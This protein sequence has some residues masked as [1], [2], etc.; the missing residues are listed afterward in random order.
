M[1]SL[2]YSLHTLLPGM[3]LNTCYNSSTNLNLFQSFYLMSFSCILCYFCTSI[4]QLA[5]FLSNYSW[6]DSFIYFLFY[7]HSFMMKVLFYHSFMMNVLF[8]IF[9]ICSES[10]LI[11]SVYL[12]CLV[13]LLF[14]QIFYTELFYMTYLKILMSKF[15]FFFLRSTFIFVCVTLIHGSWFSCVYGIF[16]WKWG[17]DLNL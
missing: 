4:F 17:T 14:L 6:Y 11:T 1:L 2:F 9:Q 15:F 12:V 8:C 5:N 16:Y 3:Q 7:N 10:L 13:N